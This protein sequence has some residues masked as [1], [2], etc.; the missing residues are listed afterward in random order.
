MSRKQLGK[1]LARMRRRALVV[2]V[3]W[4]VGAGLATAVW[5]VQSGDSDD[6]AALSRTLRHQRVRDG[7]RLAAAGDAIAQTP[8][9]GLSADTMVANSH[10]FQAELV[11]LV[12][13]AEELRMS[14][15]HARDLIR[16]AYIDDRMAQL[17][18]VV[19]VARPY[20]LDLDAWRS[21]MLVMRSRYNLIAQALDRARVLVAE[22][23]KAWGENIDGITADQMPEETIAHNADDPT[24]PENPDPIVERPPEAS[25]YR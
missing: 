25:M 1:P 6:P 23:E 16:L 12:A 7:I 3:S 10:R 4:L 15:Y 9:V 24:R 17:R 13:H 14:A 5:A 19:R 22:M 8:A 11:T 18:L 2:G 21:D 20:F